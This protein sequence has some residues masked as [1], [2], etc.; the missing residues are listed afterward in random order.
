MIEFY[1]KCKQNHIYNSSYLE[2]KSRIEENA[3]L[4]HQNAEK[5]EVCPGVWTFWDAK[6]KKKDENL[7]NIKFIP[8]V[9][10]SIKHT[11]RKEQL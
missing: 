5:G 6:N 1:T 7:L 2:L 11:G 4:Y 10:Q 9:E 3:D 8:N